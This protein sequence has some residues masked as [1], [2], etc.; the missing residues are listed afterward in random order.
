[1]I[2]RGKT[3]GYLFITDT[4]RFMGFLGHL[5]EKLEFHCFFI[6]SDVVSKEKRG[7]IKLHYNMK[8]GLEGKQG[9]GVERTG[10]EGDNHH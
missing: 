5:G 9:V 7:K 10:R 8:V 1:M 3:S 6:K 2:I 4:Q